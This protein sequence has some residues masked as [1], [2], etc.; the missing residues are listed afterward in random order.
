M[1]IV[2]AHFRSLLWLAPCY[3]TK[4]LATRLD[5]WSLCKILR[6]PYTRHVTNFTVRQN[7]GV[8]TPAVLQFPTV[9]E[10]ERDDSASS[11]MW[12][13]RADHEQDQ[14][15]VIGA[16]LR[17]PSHWRRP[18]GRPR[19]SWL[20]VIDTDV[21]SQSTRHGS[22][23]LCTGVDKGRSQG[24]R[25]LSPPQWPGKKRINAMFTSDRRY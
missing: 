15:R 22:T 8:S 17:P 14:H 20:R 9:F 1:P 2:S 4:S 18:C 24:A 5:T 23:P 21:N 12:V 11:G 16:S 10:R 25:G 6:V 3:V 19:T 7:T 13:A